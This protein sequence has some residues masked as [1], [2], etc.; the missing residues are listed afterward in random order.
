[1]EIHDDSSVF[2]ATPDIIMERDK[3]LS[4]KALSGG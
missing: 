3:S 1:M 4:T 2:M